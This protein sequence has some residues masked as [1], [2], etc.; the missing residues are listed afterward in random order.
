MFEQNNIG[1]RCEHPL[2]AVASSLHP[3]S[4]LV[5]LIL[6]SAEA[7]SNSLEGKMISGL[8]STVNLI[9]YLLSSSNTDG[10]HLLTVY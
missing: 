1:V 7:I 8:H 3:S 6:H 5:P 10:K 2:A 9:V 4:E